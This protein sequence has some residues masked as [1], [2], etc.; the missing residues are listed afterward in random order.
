MNGEKIIEFKG[1]K[2]GIYI[3][4]KGYENLEEIKNIITKKI[5]KNEDFFK[6]AMIDTIKSDLLDDV[7]ILV[8]ENYLEKEY[9]LKFVKDEI[10]DEVFDGIR[11]GNTKFLKSTLRSGAKIFFKG[12]V[13]LIG[14]VNPGAQVI[15]YGNVIITGSLRGM[16]HAGANGNEEAF[17]SANNLDPTQLRIAGK[18]AIPPENQDKPDIPEVAFIKNDNIVIESYTKNTLFN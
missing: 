5:S 18:I 14:D 16:V 4:I 17:V 13:V 7:D 12:N 9:K 10:T 6:G 1:S 3:S 8:L 2:K 15:A 11:Q